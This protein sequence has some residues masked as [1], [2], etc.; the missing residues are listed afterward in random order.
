MWATICS[1][2]LF[3]QGKKNPE[4]GNLRFAVLYKTGIDVYDKTFAMGD[5]RLIQRLNDWQQGQIGG[6]EVMLKD[7]SK[8]E[9]SIGQYLRQT[10]CRMEQ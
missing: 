5:M 2:I 1:F 8:H 3:S 6:Y 4:P 10:A 9:C 7:Y